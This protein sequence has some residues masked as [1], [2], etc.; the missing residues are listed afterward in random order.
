MSQPFKSLRLKVLIA[1]STLTLTSCSTRERVT[2]RYGVDFRSM[3]QIAQGNRAWLNDEQMRTEAHKIY[4][5]TDSV[6]LG[7]FDGRPFKSIAYSQ[8]RTI[9]LRNHFQGGII[10]GFTGLGV[11]VGIGTAVIIGAANADPARPQ[12]YVFGVF[13]IPL[14]AAIGFGIGYLIGQ[15]THYE[16]IQ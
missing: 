11:G 5:G 14:S 10:G 16:F 2:A 13:A 12:D 4:F 9:S 15:P 8:I 7:Y 6:Q 1:L 3:N